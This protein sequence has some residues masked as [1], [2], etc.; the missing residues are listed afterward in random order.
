MKYIFDYFRK[1]IGPFSKFVLAVSGQ[2]TSYTLFFVLWKA[3]LQPD[4]AFAR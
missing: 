1:P 3:L 4:K 2:F